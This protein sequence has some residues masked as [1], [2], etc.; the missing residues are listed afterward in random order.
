MTVQTFEIRADDQIGV[1]AYAGGPQAF[2]TAGPFVRWRA[3]TGRPW[4]EF[5][6][7]VLRETTQGRP[8]P[9]RLEIIKGLRTLEARLERKV[10]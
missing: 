2:D 4:S 9:G 3:A 10:T 7:E 5:R 1:T 6:F 8:N